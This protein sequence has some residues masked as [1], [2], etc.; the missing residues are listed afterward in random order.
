MGK[1]GRAQQFR[2]SK[3]AV[4]GGVDC[5]RCGKPTQRYRHP[6]DY[7]PPP[8]HKCWYRYWYICENRGCATKHI[9]PPDACVWVQP[10]E[11]IAKTGKLASKL[12]AHVSA[13]DSFNCPNDPT[14]AALLLRR[15][16]T[17]DKLRQL[18]EAIL[19]M[20]EGDQETPF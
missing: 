1:S 11:P 13:R 8:Q 2:P 5:P 20:T 7:K 15:L 12:R 18:V 10:R 6:D 9:M 19:G 17:D 3:I 4:D 14:A 16:W